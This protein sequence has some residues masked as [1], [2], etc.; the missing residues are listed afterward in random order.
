MLIKNGILNLIR[1]GVVGI[2]SGVRVSFIHHRHLLQICQPTVSRNYHIECRRN[3][4][5]LISSLTFPGQQ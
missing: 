3:M 5:G 2:F 4:P 1:I